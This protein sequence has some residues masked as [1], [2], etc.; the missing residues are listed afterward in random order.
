MM[1][2]QQRKTNNAIAFEVDIS[3]QRSKSKNSSHIQ[4][5]LEATA[6]EAAQGPQITLEQ[7]SEK[8]KRAEQKRR[9][10]LTNQ[11]SPKIEERRRNI[12]DKKKSIDR[13][14]TEQL[15][16]KIDH[17]LTTAKEKRSTT[18]EQK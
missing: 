1:L 8:L 6:K 17:S 16:E 9:E 12:R 10:T 18:M 7:I 3:G 11:V 2:H 13:S 15:K 5:K 4:K 14:T